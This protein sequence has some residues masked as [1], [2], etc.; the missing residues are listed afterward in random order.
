MV[1]I[2]SLL[3]YLSESKGCRGQGEVTVSVTV[4]RGDCLGSH[5]LDRPVRCLPFIPAGFP[6]PRTVM[7]GSA[8]RPDIA[9]ARTLLPAG[10]S[11]CLPAPTLA[12]LL[13]PERELLKG[14]TAS[15]TQGLLSFSWLPMITSS[16]SCTIGRQEQGRNRC[17]SLNGDTGTRTPALTALRAEYFS[18]WMPQLGSEGRLVWPQAAG[19]YGA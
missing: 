3:I 9:H 7:S 10:R 14:Q 18:P 8:V 6:I 19:G 13:T 11:W 17:V 4:T 12:F 5:G 2:L 1:R 15:G 16:P